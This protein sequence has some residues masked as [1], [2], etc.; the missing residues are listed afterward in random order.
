MTM[1]LTLAAIGDGFT[2]VQMA[3]DLT[4]EPLTVDCEP[5]GIIVICS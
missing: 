4:G 2:V 5:M 3:G 1:S